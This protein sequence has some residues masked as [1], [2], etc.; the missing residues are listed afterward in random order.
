MEDNQKVLWR[1]K[2]QVDRFKAVINLLFSLLLRTIHLHHHLL[3]TIRKDLGH[4]HHF[5]PTFVDELAHIAID[6]EVVCT[7]YFGELPG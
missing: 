6:V 3:L 5:I 2:P 4:L 7:I 1:T